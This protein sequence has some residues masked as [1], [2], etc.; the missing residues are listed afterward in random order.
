MVTN[1]DHLSR[2]K[3]SSALAFA[4]TEHGAVML[5]SVL[6]SSTAIQASI[7]EVRAFVKLREMLATH[8]DLA[9]KLEALE[10]KYDARFKVVFDAIRSLM[11]PISLPP[12]RQIGF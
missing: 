8:K 6:N 7:A 4:F 9:L 11:E 2:L 5:A 12:K 10:R 3:Y 1:C